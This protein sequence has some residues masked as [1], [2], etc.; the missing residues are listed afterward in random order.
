MCNVTFQEPPL[1]PALEYCAWN[2]IE[3]HPG[4]VHPLALLLASA[5]HLALQWHLRA[6]LQSLLM[7]LQSG[8]HHHQ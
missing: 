6:F 4:A 8:D 7:L 3:H 2:I 1:A 5:Q